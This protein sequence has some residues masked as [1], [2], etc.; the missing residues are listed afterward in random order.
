MSL[1]FFCM[2]DYK[3]TQRL[4]VKGYFAVEPNQL[5]AQAGAHLL[6]SEVIYS[7][8]MVKIVSILSETETNMSQKSALNFWIN[9]F[10]ERS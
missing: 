10:L 6:F 5:V 2:F 1:G 3:N 7:Y 4:P 8:Y 9:V